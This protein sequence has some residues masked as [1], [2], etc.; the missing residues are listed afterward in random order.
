MNKSSP[1]DVP[2]AQRLRELCAAAF[3]CERTARRAYRAPDKVR[4]SSLARI[5]K[6][7]RRLG[8]APPRGEHGGKP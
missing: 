4:P 2:D 3:C 1:Q 6:A 5:V 7:A 8:I